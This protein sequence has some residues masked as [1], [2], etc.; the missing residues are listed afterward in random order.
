MTLVAV[1]CLV[2]LAA[3]GEARSENTEAS[4]Q[5]SAAAERQS[6][7][8]GPR[9]P[10][11]GTEAISI[12]QMLSYQGKLTDTLGVPVGDTLHAIRF[13]LYAQATGGSAFWQEDQEVRTKGGLFSV[14][15]GAVTAIDSVPSAG[16]LYLGMAIGGGAELVPRLR[17]ASSAYSYLAARASNADLLQGRDTAALDVR[18]VNEGQANAV[19]SPMI[20]NG[21]IAAADLSQMGAASGQVMKWTGAA[22]QPRNDSVGG[23]GGAADSAWVRQGSDSVLYTIRYL[24]I[25]RGG[26]SNTLYGNQAFT[27]VNLGVACTTGTNGQN[28]NYSTVG[29]GHANTASGTEATIAGGYGSIASGLQATVGGG[30]ANAATGSAATV[31]GG[32]RDTASNGFATVGGGDHNIA[33]GSYAAVAGGGSNTAIGYYATVGGGYGDTAQADWGGVFSGRNNRAGDA[34]SDTGAAIVGGGYNSATGVWSFVGGGRGNAA[35]GNYATIGGGYADTVRAYRGG[36]SS[37]RY[38]LAGDATDDTAVIVCGGDSNRATGKFDFIGG[39]YHNNASNNYSVIAGGRNNTVNGPQASVGGGWSNLVSGWHSVIA[40]GKNNTAS[41]TSSAVSGGEYNVASGYWSIVSGGYADTAPG[42]Y[43]GVFSGR[44]NLAGDAAEDTGATVAGGGNN[45]AT[46]MWS[47]IG[48]GQHNTASGIRATVGGGYGDTASEYN[49]TVGGGFQNGASGNSATVGGGA[50]NA[51]SGDFSAVA[52]GSEDTCAEAYGF[53]TNEHS[54]VPS[55]YYNSAAFNGQTATASNQLRCGTLSKTGG[56]FTI[57]HPLDP[58]GKILNHYFVESPDMSNLYSGSVMLDATGRG[59]VRLPD[60]FD[61]LNRNP[62][63]QLTGVGTSDVFVAED[64]SRNRFAVGGKPGAKVY[65]QV[66]GDRKDVS[67]EVIRRIMPVEQHK[68]GPLVG[69]M[70]DDD[71]LAGCMDQ[72]VREGKAQGIDFRTA[73]GRARYERMKQQPEHPQH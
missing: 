43:G 14:L 66:T 61:A 12:P 11:T 24:G 35:S 16:A 32:Y 10:V 69:R 18:Y 49:A 7:L 33:S 65:W 6:A 23:G 52:G 60:Y 36:V 73:A 3:A 67:A 13:M 39:G 8:V 38:N 57:D 2:A 40:G 28:Y 31:V 63:V 46:G 58:H 9:A 27:H 41:G 72:L 22:W 44:N 62:R 48:G 70:L 26:A 42:Y 34:A 47:F 17:V 56:S 29:G 20:A 53:A 54:I 55:G 21:T 19:T 1:L 59:E 64:I 71:F 51:A 5:S 37:G 25:A 15:L 68:I 4:A 50:W 45:R 30:H